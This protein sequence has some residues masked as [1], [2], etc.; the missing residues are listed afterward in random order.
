MLLNPWFDGGGEVDDHAGHDQ[1]RSLPWLRIVGFGSVFLL[2]QITWSVLEGGAVWRTWMET[3][4]VSVA[5]MFVG[6]IIPDA[7]V[8]A[9]GTRIR[10]I[11]G[12]INLVQGCDGVE[13]LWLITAVFAVAPLT[14]PW[15]LFGWV[16]G[17]FLAW[18]LNVA[19]I[20]GLFF[21]WRTDPAWF[22]WLHNYVGPIALVLLLGLYVHIMITKAPVPEDASAQ[23][24]R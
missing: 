17:L 18:L 3:L 7:N 4:N 10:A 1:H 21:A 9:E 22:D 11:G 19:R 8:I 5:T 12:G 23:W 20:T 15:R 14:W 6:W 2:L 16:A 24:Y 13:L